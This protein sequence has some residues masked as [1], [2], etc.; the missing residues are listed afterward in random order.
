MNKPLI[1]ITGLAMAALTACSAVPAGQQAVEVDSWGAPTVSG[2]AGEE[3]NPG[4]ITVDLKRFPARQITWDANNDPGAERGP[5]VALSKP[6]SPPPAP[7][8]DPG[9]DFSSGQAEMAIPVTLTFD[10]TT[11]CDDLKTFYKDYAT[12]D[13]GWLNDDGSS[14]DGWIKLLTYTISQPAEQAVI[15]ITQ[16]Y[17]W[18]KIWNDEAVRVEYKNALQARMPEDAA[19]RTGGHQ[20]FTNFQVTVGKP[21]PTDERLRQSISDQQSSQA[22]ADAERIKLTADAEAQKSAANAQKDAAIAQQQA[23][24]EKAKIVAA[25]I[26]GYPDVESY[27]RAQ[28][29]EKGISPWPSPIIAGAPAR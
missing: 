4:T 17:P 25:Q 29:I 13:N 28:A 21:Q 9:P 6:K 1:I 3:T 24:V 23:E 27:L 7:G 16:K 26:A 10:L 8:V 5:Y 22:A 18:Q 11:N 15:S 12:K 14:S 20:Y 19:A 2:C